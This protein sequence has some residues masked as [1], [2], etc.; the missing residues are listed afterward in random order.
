MK[1]RFL[2]GVFIALIFLMGTIV[3]S[4]CVNIT[5]NEQTT[6]VELTKVTASYIPITAHFPLYV[7]EEE[8]YFEDNGLEVEMIE[9]TSPNDIVTGIVSDKIDFS[10]GLAY[11]IIFP[12]SIKYPDK[13]SIFTSAEETENKFTSSIITLKDSD[14]N[15]YHDLAGKKIGVYKGLVQTIFLKAMLTGMGIDYNQIEIIQT[16]PRLQLQGLVSGEYDALSSTEPTTIIADIQGRTK[17][18]EANPRYK[19]ILSPFPSIASVVST[20]LIEND[21]DTAKAIIKSLNSA[22]DFINTHPDTAKRHLLKYTPI[23]EDISEQ[24]LDSLRLFK[25]NKVGEENRLV[26]QRFADF[27]LDSELIKEKIDVNDLFGDGLIQ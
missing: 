17:V 7:A 16:S 3:L 24:V 26:V 21:P 18:V 25:Y 11:S 8:G 14:I 12:A 2:G 1:K 20:D 23:P 27:L 9:A 6:K 5:Q 13:F 4:G 15:S 22:I 19:H 10:A